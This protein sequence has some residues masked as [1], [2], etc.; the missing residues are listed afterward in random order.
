MQKRREDCSSRLFCL[1][2]SLPLFVGDPIKVRQVLVQTDDAYRLGK[3]KAFRSYTD[4]DGLS[5][6]N[7]FEN[8][9][10]KAAGGQCVNGSVSF[11]Q[12]NPN[13]PDSIAVTTARNSSSTSPIGEPIRHFIVKV[14]RAAFVEAAAILGHIK[15]IVRCWLIGK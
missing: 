3:R 14:F 6:R 10:P 9:I 1:V 15:K 13:V 4:N 7:I 8:V 5:C 11:R 12:I 2:R